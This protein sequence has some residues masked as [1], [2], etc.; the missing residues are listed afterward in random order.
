MFEHLF[1]EYQ[2]TWPMLFFSLRVKPNILIFYFMIYADIYVSY[3]TKG[4]HL[5]PGYFL[6]RKRERVVV[7]QNNIFFVHLFKL[8]AAELV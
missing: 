6:S 5:Y 7:L 2:L 4:N 3:E 1:L 8:I